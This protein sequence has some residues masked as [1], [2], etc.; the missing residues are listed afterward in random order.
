VRIGLVPNQPGLELLRAG[1]SV[2]PTV[3]V[4]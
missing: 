3:Q 2:V 1:M 4:R